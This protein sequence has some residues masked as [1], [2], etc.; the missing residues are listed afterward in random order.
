MC[1]FLVLLPLLAQSL[2]LMP[3]LV[4][5]T[6]RSRVNHLRHGIASNGKAVL[7]HWILSL[8]KLIQRE[9]FELM[10]QN[11]ALKALNTTLS[12]KL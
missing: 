10:M 6:L 7:T 12:T 5:T 3:G 11:P 4:P 8:N 1:I 2:A 9:Q